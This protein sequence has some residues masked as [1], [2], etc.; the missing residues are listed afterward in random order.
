MT[1]VAL[2]IGVSDYEPGLTPLPSA[3][4]DVEA[5]RQVLANPEMGGFAE[6]DI[7]VLPNPDRQTMEDAIYTLFA[8]RQKDDLLLFYFSGH[9]VVDDGGEFY[10]ASRS[11]RKDQGRL[12]PPTAVAAGSVQ[13]WMQQSRSQRQVMILDSCFSGAFAKGVTAKDSGSVNVEQFLGGR[14]R[15]ILTAA[16]STQ[17]A[18][19]HEGFDLSVYT[20]YLVEG[21]RT[22]GADL[23]DD[24][25]ITVAE[26]HDYASSKVKE[27][28]PAMTPEFYPVKDGYQILLAKSPK[29]DPKLKYR[30]QVKLVAQEDEGDFSFVNRAYLDDFQ[31]SLGLSPDVTLAIETEELEPYRQRRAKVDRYR[32]VFE[33]AIAHRYPLNDR[34]RAALQRLQQLL[35]LRDEDI[36]VI[37]APILVLKQ[38]E[39][40]QKKTAVRQVEQQQ[41]AQKQRESE[42]A[43]QRNQPISPRPTSPQKLSATPQPVDK[44][45]IQTAEFETATLTLIEKAGWFGSKISIEIKRGRGRAQYFTEDLGNDVA[46][47][48]VAI[49]AGE[50]LMGAAANEQS[51]SDGEMPQHRVKVSEFWMGKFAVTQ[52]QWRQVAGL[53]EVNLDLNPDPSNFKGSKRPVETVSWGEA[54]EFC[55]RLSRFAESR[56]SAKT[57]N[58]YHLPS[59]AE[60]EYACRAGTTTPF[61]FGATITSDLVNCDATD[62]YGNAPKGEYRKRTTEVGTFPP[63]GFGLYDMHGNV[64]E[65]CADPWHGNYQDAPTDGSVWTT[66]GNNEIRVLRGGSWI[67]NPVYCRSASRTGSYPRAT[68]NDIGFR[69]VCSSPR[70]LV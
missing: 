54:V 58:S 1:K 24:G 40:E 17:Y 46:L 57:G 67:N 21:I 45:A 65:W 28:A 36:E 31:R 25:F 59:E 63:N 18:F 6:A 42:Q 13:G 29:D 62:P 70:T 55:D 48:M 2:L 16:T 22:G 5:M 20:H 23:D 33:G 4:R 66:N 60:W 11:T 34:D 10:F 15:A 19:A 27:A 61:C 47:E 41:A 43:A 7:T 51:A 9:G 49:P 26:L 14:G 56:L 64:W 35:S 44:T 12:V 52:A 38:A 50:F 68:F 53:P 32:T 39:Y 8:N 69:I 3:V 37:E 30:K